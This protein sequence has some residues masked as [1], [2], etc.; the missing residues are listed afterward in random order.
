MAAYNDNIESREQRAESREQRAES[1]E[2][3]RI[4]YLDFVKGVAIFLVVF[5]HCIQYGNDAT[6]FPSMLYKIIYSFHM[7]LF[8]LVSGYLF[9]P[10]V[11]RRKPLDALLKQAKSFILPVASWTVIYAFIHSFTGLYRW[12]IPDY[13]A[14]VLWFLW[15]MFLCSMAVLSARVFFND[16]PIYY[17]GLLCALLFVPVAATSVFMYPYFAAGYL[18]H[19]EGLGVKTYL[20]W[21]RHKFMVTACLI[22]AWLFLFQFYT[23]EVYIY[24]SKINIF[25]GGRIDAGQL[26]LDIFR[27][28][29]GFAG[30]AAVLSLLGLVRP[31]N[32]L[33]L[34]GTKTLGIY[35]MS[36]FMDQLLPSGY[37]GYIMNFIEAS[38]ITAICYG[39]SVLISRNRTANKLLLGGR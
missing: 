13:L 7:P 24:G 12:N 29:I 30:G 2:Q 8:A 23:N 10:S 18:W 20:I 19:R 6:F 4:V 25:R 33:V 11:S 27:W 14:H 39:L 28:L 34:A 38:I 9:F 35:V 32:F 37:G 22:V 31:V 26:G 5:G 36:R 1:R 15:A 21:S 3:R 17:A 16:S